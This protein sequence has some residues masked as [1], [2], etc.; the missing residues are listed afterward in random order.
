MEDL[1]REIKQGT[2]AYI[3]VEIYDGATLS[4]STMMYDG[5]GE[6]HALN[7]NDYP[8]FAH[9]TEIP[10]AGRTWTLYMSAGPAFAMDQTGSWLILF[11]G[12]LLSILLVI[13]SS[14]QLAAKRRAK[15]IADL[16]EQQKMNQ[17]KSEFIS[18]VSH[19]LRTPLTSIKGALG[20]IS[21]GFSV[22]FPEKA[23]PL[24]QV[25]LTN[26]DRLVRLV[27][28]ILDVEKIESGKINLQIEAMDIGSLI[29]EAAL[30]NAA[31]AQEFG[32]EI[33]V[34]DLVPQGA[35]MIMGSPDRLHQVLTNLISNAVKSSPRNEKVIVRASEVSGKI[36]VQVID[37]GLGIPEDFKGRVFQK[38]AQANCIQTG[39]N[40]GT[41]LGL[42]ISKAIIEKMGGTI[43]FNSSSKSTE[44]YFYLNVSKHA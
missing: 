36:C 12:M 6:G 32:V 28:D 13:L 18:T 25:A 21:G 24:L 29:H 7:P 34:E 30:E 22:G 33:E 14:L 15:E 39:K 40:A 38:F 1:M 19:E 23:K 44:F 8:L 31:Y 9:K 3:D 4:R 17:L 41:G 35:K 20:L 10:F 26:C 42:S 2:E 5:D 27:D 43:G 11:S 37:Y 16:T